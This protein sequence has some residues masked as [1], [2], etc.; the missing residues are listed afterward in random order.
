[1]GYVDV[2][3]FHPTFLYEFL[4][5]LAAFAV[6]V[7]ADR[8]FQLGHGRVVALYVM[9]YTAGRGWIEMLRIDD[10]QMYD[11]F[12]LRLNVW[13]SIVLFVAAA[14]Y[15][16]WSARRHPG[17]ETVVYTDGAAVDAPDDA[18]TTL[19][20]RSRRRH[21]RLGGR[22]TSRRTGRP[23]TRAPSSEPVARRRPRPRSQVRVHEAR[24]APGP[25]EDRVI[26]WPR[27]LGQRRPLHRT[28][29]PPESPPL[30]ARCHRAAATDD[31]GRMPVTAP[32]AFPPT[33]PLPR[34]STTR[35]TSTTPAVSPSWR[36]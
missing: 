21:G 8:R 33:S 13:T 14:V 26:A 32:H 1:M 11:V 23:A 36:R 27:A 15:F 31:D 28:P 7:W 24:D 34:G 30:L 16:V 29:A 17:R 2:A 5:C 6:V 20:R 3:T 12:G 9:A 18:A 19:R 35:A 10:V 22:P 25:S 4:W